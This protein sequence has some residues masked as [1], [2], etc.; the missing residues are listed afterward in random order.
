MAIRHT[1]KNEAFGQGV[2]DQSKPGRIEYLP[3]QALD[4]TEGRFD[5]VTAALSGRGRGPVSFS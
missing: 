4:Y 5:G 3:R 2:A 1:D